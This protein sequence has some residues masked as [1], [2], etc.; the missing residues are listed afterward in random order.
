M[1]RLVSRPLSEKERCCNKQGLIP[2]KLRRGYAKTG[3]MNL[4]RTV[5]PQ[6]FSRLLAEAKAYPGCEGMSE[7]DIRYWLDGRLTEVLATYPWWY[8]RIDETKH[9]EAQ[10]R[11][12]RDRAAADQRDTLAK[13]RVRI[14]ELGYQARK[15]A[16]AKQN[17]PA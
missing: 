15:A 12:R 8:G 3:W 2:G 5:S 7:E 9:R 16:L 14:Y 6:T 11:Y 17:P 13:E 1:P 4:P 10:A